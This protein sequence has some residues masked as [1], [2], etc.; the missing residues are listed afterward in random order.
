MKTNRSFRT[1]LI[2]LVLVFASATLATAAEEHMQFQ[3]ETAT[4]IRQELTSVLEENEDVSLADMT[5]DQLFDIAGRLS[6]REQEGHYIEG[7]Q[8]ASFMLPGLGQFGTGDPLA[9]SLFLGG[10]LTLQ[11]GTIT[12]AYVLLPDEVKVGGDGLDYAGDSF[13]DIRNTWR[14]LS[15]S[16]LGPSFGVLAGG[17]IVQTAFRAWSASDAGNRATRNVEDGTVQF[18]P[19]PFMFVGDRLGFGTSIKY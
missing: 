8:R 3:D 10:H 9:G 13:N 7:K 17:S 11:A 6:V 2:T 16:D 4:R 1:I 14:S 5:V 18:D 15:L 12:G 19:Q